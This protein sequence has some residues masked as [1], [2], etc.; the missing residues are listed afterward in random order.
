MGFG[1]GDIGRIGVG[2]GTGGLSEVA[3]DDG[4]LNP[5]GSNFLGAGPLNRVPAAEEHYGGV[6]PSGRWAQQAE[7]AGG[8]GRK[9]MADFYSGGR[10]AQAQRGQMQGISDRYGRIAQGMDS[11]SAEQLR[12]GLGQNQAAQMSM[13]AGAAPQNQAMAARNAMMNMS[14]Q[15]MGMSGQAAMAGLQERRDALG[16]QAQM[17]GLIQQGIMGQRGQN[18]QAGLGGTGMAMQGYG[19]IEGNRTSRYG[20]MLGVPTPAEQM[21]GMVASGLEAFA[22]GG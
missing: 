9:G 5:S 11:I 4:V 7:N 16:A 2:I 12:Q 21:T 1:W 18:L 19:G 22:K 3:R 17:Q 15:G 6:D 8:F 20:A 10:E 14:R 13:A